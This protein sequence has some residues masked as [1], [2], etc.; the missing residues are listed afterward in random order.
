MRKYQRKTDMF[1]IEPQITTLLKDYEDDIDK[2]RKIIEKSSGPL[3]YIFGHT[4][5]RGEKD[6]RVMGSGE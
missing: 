1:R 6:E 4:L 3:Y 5:L 2:K